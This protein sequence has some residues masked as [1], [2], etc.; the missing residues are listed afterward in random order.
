V[1]LQT[2][3]EDLPFLMLNFDNNP[4]ILFMIIINSK[5]KDGKHCSKHWEGL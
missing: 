4:L 1:V 5:F 2:T 3:I